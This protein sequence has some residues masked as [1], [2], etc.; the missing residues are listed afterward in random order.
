M[1]NRGQKGHHKTG[2]DGNQCR[3]V[4]I[5]KRTVTEYEYSTLQSLE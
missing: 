3:N 4:L 2:Y 5:Y 1:K